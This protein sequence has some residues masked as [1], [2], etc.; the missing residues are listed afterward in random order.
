[1]TL[2][3]VWARSQRSGDFIPTRLVRCSFLTRRAWRG[4]RPSG[5]RGPRGV[6]P[7]AQAALPRRSEAVRSAAER[8]AAELR[9]GRGGVLAMRMGRSRGYIRKLMRP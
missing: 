2:G 6:W 5:S 4:L 9:R 7:C 1:V 3:S 8:R